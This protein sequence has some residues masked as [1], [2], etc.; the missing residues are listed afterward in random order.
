MLLP[1][2]HREGEA[3]LVQD[4]C[5]TYDSGG[6][7]ICHLNGCGDIIMKAFGNEYA[8]PLITFALIFA[9][10]LLFG[11]IFILQITHNFRNDIQSDC[12][13]VK[14]YTS[15]ECSRTLDIG[16]LIF[17]YQPNPYDPDGILQGL[18]KIKTYRGL[19]Q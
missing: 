12:I 11:L 10:V 1:C 13:Q 3:K 15:F 19:G 2:S 14:A 5:P 8:P 6:R 7:R 9:T 18:K 4:S 16:R 17:F